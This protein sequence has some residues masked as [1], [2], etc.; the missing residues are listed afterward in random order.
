MLAFLEAAR[1]G[2]SGWAVDRF[3]RRYRPE[4]EGRETELEGT[5]N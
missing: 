4:A 1:R 2:A 5:I 3:D